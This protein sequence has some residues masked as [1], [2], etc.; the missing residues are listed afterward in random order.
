MV[1]DSSFRWFHQAQL[2]ED[3][4][5]QIAQTNGGCNES[6]LNYGEIGIVVGIP[7]S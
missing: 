2:L 7:K 1:E 3:G 5:E 4:V 6:L